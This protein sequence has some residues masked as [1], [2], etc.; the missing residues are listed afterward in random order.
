MKISIKDFFCKSGQIRSFLWIWSHELK[1]TWMENVILCTVVI[2]LS[3][4]LHQ[5][6]LL[7]RW[8]MY[9]AKREDVP[10]QTKKLMSIR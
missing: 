5:M 8:S 9:R 10:R 2:K 1:K 3:L 6:K 7:K 4:N